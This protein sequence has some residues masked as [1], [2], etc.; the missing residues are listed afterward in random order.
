MDALSR[1][2][3]PSML[4][5][6]PPAA[7]VTKFNERVKRIGKVNTEI[8]DWLQERRKVEEAYVAGL[9]KLARRPLQELGGELGIFDSPWKKIVG[10][11][12]EIASSHYTLLQRIEKDVEEPLRAFSTTNREMQSMSTVQ[13]NLSTMAKELQDAQEK[14]DKLS[15]R[16]GK[17]SA[18]KVGQASSKLQ[19]AESQWDSQ[20]PFIFESLQALDERRLNHLRDVLTQFETHQADQVE[21]NRITVEQTLSSLLEIDTAQE[22]R[23]WSSQTVAGKPITERKARQLSTSGSTG[24][25]ATP[26]I[27]SMPPPPTPRSTHTTHTNHTDDRSEHSTRPH[28]ESLRSRVGT[29][30]GRRR[31]S[32]HGGFGR[33][34]SPSKGG[35]VPF[36]RDSPNRD[37]RPSP[38]PRASS[39]NLRDSPS[40]DNR[41][42]SLAE[43][44]PLR[45]PA[46]PTNGTN[47]VTPETSH[48]SSAV[49]G[50]ANGTSLV[51]LSD[52]QPPPGPPPSHLNEAQK[53]AEGY[54]VPA[55]MNDP[56]SLAESEAHDGNEPQFKL[57]IRADPIPE[58]DADAQAALSNVANTLRSAKMIPPARKV[59]TIRGR[60]DVRNTIFV[61]STSTSLE[62]GGH[63]PMPPSPGI[64][65]GRAAA[66]AAL[67]S[68]EHHSAPSV[69]DSTSIRS[70][71]SLNN[72]SV[73]KHAEMHQ[74]G[75]NSSIIETLSASFENGIVKTS[76]VSGEIALTYNKITTTD[77]SP[78]PS[79][80]ENETVRINNFQSLEVIGPNRTFIHPVSSDITD[81]YT[82]DLNAISS[83]SIPAFTYR[84]HTDDS[85]VTSQ[86]PLLL[87]PAWKPQG[88][89][90][91]LLIEYSLNPACG[92]TS[93][94]FTN[95]VLMA[96]YTGARPTAC[97]TK[98][99]GTHLSA[100]SLVYWRLG[101][102]TL[103][104]EPH[105][106]ICRLVGAS[107]PGN[108]EAKWEVH[109]EIGEGVGSGISLSRFEAGKGKER[110]VDID[111][112]FADE[113][114]ASPVGNWIDV[115]LARKF[116]SGKYEAR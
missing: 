56:I 36:G 88:D 42:S 70:G 96:I 94:T 39:N 4:E 103:T 54:T 58:Q 105:K 93:L 61:P 26:S 91:N 1:Q 57:D 12:E 68:N 109:S 84:V 49:P 86:G 28:K 59:G 66:L 40:H 38:S 48:I 64:P 22:I 15:K 52:V 79:A 14:A 73:I 50:T 18:Q 65:A 87:K 34:P 32:I 37:G 75:L 29:M 106:V 35:F 63:E 51:D 78:I 116:V 97:Q 31:Q 82:I 81:Q 60:R 3:Y 47:G 114:L 69:S 7:A 89:K 6:L 104:H 80:A 74:P 92:V 30:V 20:A 55:M 76:K 115:P 110:E 46:S 5:R 45:S 107:E 11:T 8:A 25:P 19:T 100:R 41:L 17:A 23:N 44:P 10:S 112:P 113:G 77:E 13:G 102:V 16:G 108:V 71:H 83:R 43:S 98:P 53:D 24:V 72:H 62:V 85:N 33:A 27:S 99:T 95:L 111:D 2:E 101:D 9:K 90:L 21:R 67:S